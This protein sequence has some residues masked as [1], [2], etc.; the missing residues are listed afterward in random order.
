MLQKSSCSFGTGSASSSAAEGLPSLLHN[1]S[2]SEKDDVSDCSEGCNSA[3]VA[4]SISDSEPAKIPKPKP[5]GRAAKG[6]LNPKKKKKLTKKKTVRE[7]RPPPDK[8]PVN[9]NLNPLA[10]ALLSN[11]EIG[12][13]GCVCVPAKKGELK[14]IIKLN[15]ALRSAA[16]KRK[17]AAAK[18][19]VT[20]KKAAKAPAAKATAI[21]PAATPAAPAPAAKPTAASAPAVKAPP[22]RSRPPAAAAA[23]VPG[24]LAPEPAIDRTFESGGWSY[25][26]F[27]APQNKRN[28]LVLFKLVG[29]GG[30]QV[31][32]ISEGSIGKA[33][34][35]KVANTICDE[36]EAGALTMV[37]ADLSKRR[38]EL[39]Q[40][41]VRPI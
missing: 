5:K 8:P 26:T 18:A 14:S 33:A 13:E 32:Q 11:D 3:D 16:K 36:V 4:L 25:R 12:I 30:G 10:G 1:I 6:G 37:A 17:A 2:G 23:S 29:P 28:G 27:W 7:D 19:E 38:S 35:I 31:F 20:R 24:V 15:K 9:A 22:K 34:A 21:L 39:I 40:R 41:I